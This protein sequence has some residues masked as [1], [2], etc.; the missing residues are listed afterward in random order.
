MRSTA[1]AAVES[2]G[3]LPP[4]NSQLDANAKMRPPVPSWTIKIEPVC[5]AAKLLGLANVQDDVFD[6]TNEK[7]F[8]VAKSSVLTVSTAA[9]E[10]AEILPLAAATV[11]SPALLIVMPPTEVSGDST[12]ATLSVDISG[13]LYG[14][15]GVCWIAGVSG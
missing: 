7:L 9:T 6:S 5:P 3:A 2:V 12:L 11:T 14:P 10:P 15:G 1:E 13:R 8:D 4:A